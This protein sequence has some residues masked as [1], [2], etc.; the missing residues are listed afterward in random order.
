MTDIP[1]SR[2]DGGRYEIRVRGL[3]ATRWAD[4]FEGFTLTPAGDDTTVLE[5]YAV[6][7][8]ALHGL[9]ARIGDLGLPLLALD[10]VAESE[11]RTPTKGLR[12]SVS[13][14]TLDSVGP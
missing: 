13:L 3:L 8:A 4:W 2:S 7:Q 11:G 12:G 10:R 1:T 6:D 9:L 14:T 5:G